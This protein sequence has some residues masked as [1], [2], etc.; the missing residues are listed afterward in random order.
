MNSHATKFG[1][2]R[3]E[4]LVLLIGISILAGAMATPWLQPDS[5]PPL[6]KLSEGYIDLSRHDFQKNNVVRL[7][8]EWEFYWN[9]LLVSKPSGN[10]APHYFS[11][12]SVWSHYT[13]NDQQLPRYGAATYRIRLLLPDKE[14]SY[15]IRIPNIRTAS[16]TYVNG[17]LVG[18]A[19]TPALTKA[20]ETPRNKPYTFYF[21][22]TEREVELIIEVSN[23]VYVTSGI[24][25]AIYFGE[26]SGISKLA[27]RNEFYDVALITSVFILSIF[28]GIQAHQ[29]KTDKAVMP[30]VISGLFGVGY[31]LTH[32]E[33]MLLDLFPDLSNEWF[34]KIQYISSVGVPYSLVFYT[35][36]LSSW[37]RSR[38]FILLLS[39]ISFLFMLFVLVT[40]ASVYTRMLTLILLCI[41]LAY[42]YMVTSMIRGIRNRIHGTGYMIVALLALIATTSTYILTTIVGMEV[43]AIP[44]VSIPLFVL[45]QGILL[46]E[47]FANAYNQIND[48]SEQLQKWDQ[49][50]D[51]FL[52]RTSF[53]IRSPLQA[54]RHISQSLLQ[55]TGGKLVSTHRED[56]SVVYHTAK[57][58]DFLV[59]DIVA[60]GQIRM[61][62]LQVG[63]K[64]VDL[65]RVVNVL[66][67]IVP[68]LNPGKNVQIISTIPADTYVV[69]TDEQRLEQILF[70]LLSN[71]LAHTEQ[72]QITI[73]CQSDEQYA[74]VTIKDTGFGM[75]QGTIQLLSDDSFSAQRMTMSES[76]LGL[77][78]AKHLVDQLGGKIKVETEPAQGTSITVS[79]PLASL[80]KGAQHAF[81]QVAATTTHQTSQPKETNSTHILI[82]DDQYSTRKA[83]VSL[84]EPEGYSVSAAAS[85]QEAMAI[86]SG[87]RGLDLCIVASTLPT[88]SGFELCQAIRQEHSPFDLPVL[89]LLTGWNRNNIELASASGANDY[90]GGSYDKTE[91]LGKVNTLVQ[92]K[93][94]V[95]SLVQTELDMLRAQIKPH[96]LF[97]AINTIIWVSKQDIGQTRQLLRDLSDFLRG[98]FDFESRASLVP[99]HSELE[100]T[101]AYL[102]LEQAR[103]GDRLRVSYQ[104]ETTDFALPPLVIQP[105]VENAIRH[106]LMNTLDGGEVS[107]TT[108][109]G[110]GCVEILIADDGTGISQAQIDSIHLPDPKVLHASGTGIGLKNTNRRLLKQFGTSL[111]VKRR[112]N[113]GTE[114]KIT[115]PLPAE[116]D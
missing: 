75:E 108:R 31:L 51:T 113:G 87:M 65:V 101:K 91:L 9:Q 95:T 115:I 64:P 5:N 54:I 97:N 76:E 33:K 38:L 11:V 104:L 103:F 63:R 1:I 106:G 94:S 90:L 110:P 46:S 102:A 73:S 34:S 60:Y 15:G 88:M 114:V 26:Q 7:S 27:T 53:G 22:S 72:G 57:K 66:M 84:L 13:I 47:R 45:M 81:S 99:F 86:M 50:K 80:I 82:V 23:H 67:D 109:N 56:L 42:G 36:R 98:S 29:R 14:A 21:Q 78:I 92:L 37:V 10:A 68:F 28:F 20:E 116:G 6:M 58:L 112:E 8:G 74:F 61:G 43:Y 111:H 70:H 69:L 93:R 32:S 96:F 62:S 48:L 35:Y 100:L 85:G 12:P 16:R 17:V 89:L 83:L 52:L 79:L 3:R 77:S 30:L 2:S 19:G 24:V 18:S 107:I 55:G 44:P 25:Q 59:K 71:A 40:D 41:T 4:W 39:G 49:F 105:L